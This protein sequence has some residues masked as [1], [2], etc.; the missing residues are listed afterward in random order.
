[1]QRVITA[2]AVVLAS[3]PATAQQQAVDAAESVVEEVLVTSPEPRYVAP[4]TRDRIGRIWAPVLINGQGPYRLV[5]DTGASRSALVQRVVDELALPVQADAVRLRGVTGTAIASA[6]RVDS[7]EFGELAIGQSRLPVVADAFGGADGVLGG[8]GLEDK[9]ITIEFRKDR[10]SIMRSHRRPAALGH[11]VVPFKYTPVRGMR[12]QVQVGS[13]KAVGM[14][15]TGA[16]VTVGN[17]ALREALAKRRGQ[18]DQYDDVVI[19]ITEDIQQATRVR[20]PSILAGQMIVRNAEI[21]FSDLHIFEH[22][23]L[24]SQPALLIGMDVLGTLD[25]LVI[26]YALGQL[27]LRTR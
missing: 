19:G 23:R 24:T 20:V 25:T 9:R 2:T 13:V 15:D 14:I 1:M 21:R 5:L 4:T 17:L 27:Q 3:L 12:V 26:D 7:L 16:Q 22:W 10:I 6:V 11:A 8:E 18:R